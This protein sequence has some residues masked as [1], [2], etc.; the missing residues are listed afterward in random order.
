MVDGAAGSR[1][2]ITRTTGTESNPRWARNDTHVTYGQD[3]NLFMLPVDGG[4]AALVAQLT[5]VAP[6]RAEPRLTESQKFLRDEEEKLIAYVREQKEQQK[7]DEQKA[8]SG[9]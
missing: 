6:K 4:S 5:D 7:K 2:Q 3:G 8:R 1:R 9:S